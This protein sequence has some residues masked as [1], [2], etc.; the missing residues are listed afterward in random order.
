MAKGYLLFHDVPVQHD[1][2]MENID[3]LAVG[4]H[5][6]VV[7]ETKTRSISTKE[8]RGRQEVTFD[9]EKLSWPK[10]PEDRKTVQQVRRCAQWIADL[11]RQECGREIPVQ[12]IIAIPGWEVVP[13]KFYNPRV[14][15]PGALENGFE[16]MIANQPNVLKP[17]EIKRFAAKIETLC[18]DID[19]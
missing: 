15:H 3:H 17:A 18:R 5:G 10:F 1:K 19:W 6:L 12:Q 2:S 16:M 13:G 11:A 4:P 14:L 8:A 7:I 9:G